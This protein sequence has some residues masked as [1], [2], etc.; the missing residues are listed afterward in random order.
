MPAGEIDLP[1]TVAV[2]GEL[3]FAR[4]GMLAGAGPVWAGRGR[5]AGHSGQRHPGNLSEGSPG[6]VPQGCDLDDLMGN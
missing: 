4:V 5:V 6:A 3:D 2:C 1:V